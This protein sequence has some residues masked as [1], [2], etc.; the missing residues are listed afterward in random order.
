MAKFYDRAIEFC[1][2][3]LIIFTPLAFGSVEIWSITIMELI[4]VF[5]STLWMLK[6]VHQGEIS[7]VKTPLNFPIFLFLGLVVFQLLPLS[8][9]HSLFPASIYFPATKTAFL[10]VLTYALIFFVF[11]N[12]IQN[13][14]QLH[15][16][17]VSIIIIGSFIALYGLI[18]YLTGHQMIFLYQK[19]YY[20]DCVTGTFINRN[21]FAGYMEMV[22]PLSLGFLLATKVSSGGYLPKKI[23][24]GFLI[25]IMAGAVILSRSR[26]GIL[27]LVASLLFMGLMY[28]RRKSAR[29]RTLTIV[30]VMVAAILVTI[31]LGLSPVLNRFSLLT[32]ELD[33]SQGRLAVWKATI[34]LIK[35]YP[36][37]G[38]GL[39]TFGDIFSR[40]KPASIQA[41]FSH[42]H[43]D[44]LEFISDTG[45]VGFSIA[46]W[47]GISSLISSF[48]RNCPIRS[49]CLGGLAAMVAMLIHSFADFNLHIPANALLLVI[50]ISLTI[51]FP[52]L[53][54]G[55][56]TYGGL[57]VR[58]SYC[59]PPAIRLFL[60][61]GVLSLA[62][63][64]SL[65]V[66]KPYLAERHFRLASR[67]R[68]KSVEELREAISLAP[69]NAEYHYQLAKVMR[70][71]SKDKY[72]L[73][74]SLCEY[75][76]AVTLNPNNRKYH[77]ALAWAANVGNEVKAEEELDKALLC[78]PN[79][80]YTHYNIGTYYLRKADKKRAFGEYTKANRLS[81]RYLDKILEKMF[82]ITQDY[83]QLKVVIPSNPEAHLILAN[84][85]NEKDRWPESK[86]EYQTA[87]NLLEKGENRINPQ[88]FLSK[89]RAI[90]S[91]FAW[92]LYKAGEFGESIS[93]WL[94]LMVVDPDNQITYKENIARCYYYNE[95]Y[96]ETIKQS[97]EILAS[98]PSYAKAHYWLGSAYAKRGN[99]LEAIKEYKKAISLDP[100][101]EWNYIQLARAYEKENF[102]KQ[103]LYEWE[104]SA[105]LAPENP[106]ARLGLA[107]IYEKM[108]KWDK[109]IAEYKELIRLKP[110]NQWFLKCLQRLQMDKK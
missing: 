106:S 91:S 11:I 9:I 110:Q 48:R 12:N 70:N 58:R 69:A 40:Y 90:C 19:K 37:W 33:F 103:A 101:N 81:L 44:Y 36:I 27:S 16:I 1:L 79:D 105:N 15:R 3:S 57:F 49:I 102:P 52:T 55:S 93:Q 41:L 38:T 107:L 89:Q 74:S 8:L 22:I 28:W 42:T 95:Q 54:I 65:A 7:F 20:T 62:L 34:S 50:I 87:I 92:A 21:H 51:V 68:A 4:V 94:K 29:K 6:M 43:N 72:S 2:I 76:R 17:V 99:R 59:L 13:E 75:Q 25:V 88:K 82:K 109:A 84:F 47:I 85:L 73:D 46:I 108:E 14:R 56:R 98:Q 61:P 96:E 5:I 39:G 45:V 53:K 60:Y 35:D 78:E 66:I 10:K 100:E 80:A 77:L 26:M 30:S 67:Q 23:L 31:W 86:I 63:L 64:L 32:E 18:E 83:H 97:K 71:F 104:K 24:L